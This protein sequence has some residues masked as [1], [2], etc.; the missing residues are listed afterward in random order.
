MHPFGVALR[1]S[2]LA[3]AS[4]L[5]GCHL[6]EDPRAE[7]DATD[8]FAHRPNTAYAV[9][10][11]RDGTRLL[12]LLEARRVDAESHGVMISGWRGRVAGDAVLRVGT[13]EDAGRVVATIPGGRHVG[14]YDDASGYVFTSELREWPLEVP[15]G[16]TPVATGF[17]KVTIVDRA[18]LNV[19]GDIAF[20]P[21][22]EDPYAWRSG[23]LLDG[24]R[25]GE[26]DV[27]RSMD[28]TAV[29]VASGARTVL[30]RGRGFASQRT[31]CGPVVA[32]A[33]RSDD[34]A[35]GT[36]LVVVD[37]ESVRTLDVPDLRPKAIVCR[38]SGTH[39]AV[40]GTR[41][42]AHTPRLVVIDATRPTGLT[43]TRDVAA[44]TPA[45][46]SR[47][48]SILFATHDEHG[49]L[50][51]PTGEIEEL[52][53]VR[54]TGAASA[55]DDRALVSGPSSGWI[56]RLDGRAPSVFPIDRPTTTVVERAG[57]P[58]AGGRFA[59][60]DTKDDAGS[61]QATLTQSFIVDVDGRTRDLEMPK[62]LAYPKVAYAERD[63]AVL[64]ASRLPS[65]DT[66]AFD[67]LVLDVAAGTT[68][69]A[70]RDAFCDWRTIQVSDRCL[71]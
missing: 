55:S 68:T 67:A 65:K 41:D 52:A 26:S 23:K 4:A 45:A 21:P 70:L 12:F 7:D 71:P 37:G 47:D 43:L 6:F 36:M 49:F 16:E 48:G 66:V 5:A 33:H 14:D 13:G 64:V 56:V 54:G 22:L 10:P 28:L 11:S 18:T 50:A 19:T 59:F 42:D 53:A 24:P 38:S 61:D 44:S 60:F 62:T 2:A 40:V 32:L 46:L 31:T 35:R 29:D 63:H 57:S 3:L 58:L 17:T 27:A 1:V 69:T 9:I 20:D 8:T 15:F 39:V 51:G 30:Y 25:S 34:K